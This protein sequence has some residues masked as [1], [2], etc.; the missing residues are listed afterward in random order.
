MLQQDASPG[1]AMSTVSSISSDRYITPEYLAHLPTSVS[2]HTSYQPS[3][4][5]YRLFGRGAMFKKVCSTEQM[6]KWTVIQKSV[7]SVI[8]S[9]VL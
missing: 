3:Q 9:V 2:S 7:R 5:V 1:P 6:N 8:T 4:A